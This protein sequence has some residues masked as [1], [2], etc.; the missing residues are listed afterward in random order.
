MDSSGAR[1]LRKRLEAQEHWRQAEA[2]RC[3]EQPAA[4]PDV[5]ELEELG[6]GLRIYG[7]ETQQTTL[8]GKPAIVTQR[9]CKRLTEGRW[10]TSLELERVRYLED[11]AARDS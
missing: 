3:G 4:D 1:E 10:E 8:E 9:L 11:T 6:D 7:R 2:V 5:Q